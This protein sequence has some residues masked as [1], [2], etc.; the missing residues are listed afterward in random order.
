VPPEA[1]APEPLLAPDALTPPEALDEDVLPD[2]APGEATVVVDVV[3]VEDV[4]ELPMAAS[5]AAAFGTV[6]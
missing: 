5:A 2:A 3:L 1:V 6:N 4:D